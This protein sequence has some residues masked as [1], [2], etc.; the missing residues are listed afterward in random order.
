MK[1]IFDFIDELLTLGRE[2]YRVP[3]TPLYMLEKKELIENLTQIKEK[4]EE[5]TKKIQNLNKFTALQYSAELNGNKIDLFYQNFLM[6]TNKINSQLFLEINKKEIKEDRMISLKDTITKPQIFYDLEELL[7]N[8]LHLFLEFL[9]NAKT[10]IKCK[11]VDVIN[12]KKSI[13][14]LLQN[15]QEKEQ[16]IKEYKKKIQDYKWLE[17]KEK[18]KES[19]VINLENELIKKI[20]ISEKKETMLNLYLIKI[21]KDVSEMY[22]NIKRLT[23][24][25][26]EIERTN[27]DKE[28]NSLELI[29]ELKQELLSTRYALSKSYED[30]V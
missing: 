2:L 11:Y 27:K 15:I 25:I 30:K 9:E 4:L 28:E 3:P 19:F 5:Y 21:E 18:A 14:E 17:A 10:K 16:T 24:L 6:L 8:E 1:N 29:K 26:S 23:N 7:K 20:K 22:Q 13:D 12:Q